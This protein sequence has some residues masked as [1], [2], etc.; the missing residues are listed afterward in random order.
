MEFYGRVHTY[1]LYDLVFV[2]LLYCFT[3]ELYVRIW[4][5]IFVVLFINHMRLWWQWGVPI[6]TGGNHAEIRICSLRMPVHLRCWLCLLTNI[7]G[8]NG[9]LHDVRLTYCM[10]TRKF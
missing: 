6:N 9:T 8:I 10:E 5:E 1:P 3:A 2:R 4:N 7:N